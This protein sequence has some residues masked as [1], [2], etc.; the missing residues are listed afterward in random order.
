MR[1][2]ETLKNLTLVL[3]FISSLV[4][5]GQIFFRVNSQNKL[6]EE[7][8]SVWIEN[9]NIIL[10]YF[11]PQS[12]VINFGGSLHTVKYKISAKKTI[13]EGLS[14]FIKRQLDE[15]NDINLEVKNV[16]YDDW[17]YAIDKRGIRFN[18]NYI[19]EFNHFMSMII[20]S[21]FDSEI[22]IKVSE[23]NLLQNGNM[24][25]KNE[26]GYFL[27]NFN[28]DNIDVLKNVI[29]GFEESYL[30]YKTLEEMYSLNKILDD[31][32]QIKINNTLMPINKIVDIPV[33]EVANEVDIFDEENSGIKNYATKILG[34]NFIR[35][36]YDYEGSLIYM[37]GY[38][39]KA[40]KITNDGYFEYSQKQLYEE[41]ELSF[42]EGL[43]RSINVLSTI[44]ALPSDIYLSNYYTYKKDEV[45]IN[46]YEFDYSYGGYEV[47]LGNA[48]ESS[49]VV[50]FSGS[51]LL[52][53]KRRYKRF[54]SS[55]NVEKVWD[56]ALP[57]NIV[58]NKN[59]DI[60]VNDYIED[61]GILSL[62]NKEKYIYKILQDIHKLDIKYFLR[63]VDYEE[64]LV[65]V[66]K[67]EVNNRIYFINI[68]NGFIIKNIKKGD[69]IELEKS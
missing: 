34:N 64:K 2:K 29:V 57:I 22:K 44:N 33:I 54:L 59:Y 30:E 46:R 19:M 38:G 37:T 26:D 53:I 50:E 6:I 13:R 12:Y 18:T 58:I 5:S 28:K 51:K 10:D 4:L 3:L 14:K 16:E 69:Y 24:F 40:L 60:I 45:I 52:N 61:N 55:I 66:W 47:I 62:K 31:E 32:N 36:V 67:L 63:K 48:K 35:K 20:N 43:N 68:Y 1:S 41:D 23:V 39:K 25:I 27:V 15:K 17:Q 49:F 65:P 56:S 8:K 42:V 7:R 9:E 21:E 11:N